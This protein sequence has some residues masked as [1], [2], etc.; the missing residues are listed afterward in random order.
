MPCFL[1]QNVLVILLE[2]PLP[3]LGLG[4]HPWPRVSRGLGEETAL[5][6]PQSPLQWPRAPSRSRWPAGRFLTEPVRPFPCSPLQHS[7]QRSS[8]KPG[9]FL[10]GLRMV[11]LY[12][13]MR[14]GFPL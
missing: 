2:A 9:E 6:G 12:V 1:L 7:S 10:I 8:V 14:L 13:K 11:I 5:A 4:V 3:A